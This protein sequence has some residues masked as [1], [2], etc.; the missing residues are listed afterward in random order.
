MGGSVVKKVILM[1]ILLILLC[2]CSP[3][4]ATNKII[5]TNTG[6]EKIIETPLPGIT[7]TTLPPVIADLAPLFADNTLK[8]IEV[9]IQEN[10]LATAGSLL[11]VKLRND[12]EYERHFSLPCGYTFSPSIHKDYQELILIQRL[13]FSMQPLDWLVIDPIIVSIEP[14]K[15]IPVLGEPYQFGPMAE[16]SLKKFADCT[17]G[18]KIE[19]DDDIIL[20]TQQVAYWLVAEEKSSKYVA[21]LSNEDFLGLLKN[22]GVDQATLD[23]MKDYAPLFKLNVAGALL[24][25]GY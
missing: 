23:S 1:S 5:A 15:L 7:S 6:Q 20:L 25:C 14:Y 9:I 3:Q 24:T 8:Q 10:D 12:S 11:S 21:G 18:K 22:Y 4:V 2:S 19:P 16:G 17:C 13:D